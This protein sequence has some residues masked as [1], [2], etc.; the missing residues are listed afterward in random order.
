M[1]RRKAGMKN[2]D[3]DLQCRAIFVWRKEASK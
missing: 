2:T 1:K 3:N